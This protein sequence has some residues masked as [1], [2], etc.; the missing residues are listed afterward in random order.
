MPETKTKNSLTL[1]QRYR[2]LAVEQLDA[3]LRTVERQRLTGR[4]SVS[5]DAR[6]GLFACPFEDIHRKLT[7]PS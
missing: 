2:E 5:I 7:S 6:D 4:F 3:L 1:S